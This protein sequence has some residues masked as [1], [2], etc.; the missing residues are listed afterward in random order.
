MNKHFT[1]ALGCLLAGSL[2]VACHKGDKGDKGTDNGGG[3]GGTTTAKTD[4]DSL[5]YLMYHTM[6]VSFV[7]GGRSTSTSYPTY[8]WYSQVPTLDPLA[9][10]Y[11][12]ADSLLSVIKTYSTGTG[13][14]GALDRYSFLDR[15]GNV[16][17]ELQDGVSE[18]GKK[19]SGSGTLGMEVSYAYNSQGGT[20]LLVLYADKNSPAGQKG[21][22]RGMQIVSINGDSSIAYDGANGTNTNKVINAI[23]G[24]SSVTLGLKNTLTDARN[25]VSVTPGTYNINPV[26]FDTTYTVNN[27]KVGYF[28]FYTFTSTVNTS[29]AYTPTKT[30]LDNLLNKYKAAGIT[31]LIV[32][33]RYNGGGSVTTAEYLDSALA[34]AA[35]AGQP[36]YYYKYNDKLTANAD[37][38]GLET[39][40]NF[41]STTGGQTLQNIFFIVSGNTASA[42]ELT[43]NNLKPYFTGSNSVKLIGSTTYGKPVGFITFTINDYDSTHKEHY[44]ADL[45]AIN[46]ATENAN[47]VGG[48]YSGI[49]PDQAEDDYIDVP[50]GNGY[51]VCLTAALNYVQ[52]GAFGRVAARQA[53]SSTAGQRISS[54]INLHQFNGMVDYRLSKKLKPK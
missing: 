41:P 36:M 27:Q 47:H 5:K 24:T 22:T 3:G 15:T 20:D 46:F 35:A 1:L 39:Q 45:Y 16:S 9:S 37:Q 13:G 8:Y 49:T 19:I 29:G 40:V 30:I 31:N 11:A 6:Q 25:T 50:W 43:M 28:V 21:I 48:Y 12:N 2:F 32:D 17:S 4:E 10:T 18:L 23:Y 14:T 44:L 7:D 34:P 26:L 33:L 54:S 51:D 53:S 52:T 42:S 38:L